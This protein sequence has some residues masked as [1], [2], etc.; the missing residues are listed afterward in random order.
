MRSTSVPGTPGVPGAETFH[1][2][3]IDDLPVYLCGVLGAVSFWSTA[4]AEITAVL[5]LAAAAAR[6]LIS[7]RAGVPPEFCR[8]RPSRIA[9]LLLAVYAPAT[10]VS[11]LL[12]QSPFLRNPSILWH[13]LLLPA[14][15]C[16]AV[17]PSTLR[18]AGVIFIA[19]GAASSVV[20]LAVNFGWS[21]AAGPF[22]FTGL[23]T[24]ADLLV[25]AGTAGLSLPGALP[26]VPFR[27]WPL[28][29]SALVL[30]AIAWTGERAPVVAL[31]GVG[32]VR[33]AGGGRRLFVAW[34]CIVAACVAIIP[35]VFTEK[36]DWLMSGRQIDRYVV[37]EEG[38]RLAPAAP[39]FG[40]GPGSFARV[41][42]LDAWGKFMQRPP[43]SWHNDLLETWL[44]SG[45]LAAVALGGLLVAGAVQALRG[46]SA[47]A[48]GRRR[49]AAG[50]AGLLFMILA[51]FGAVGSVVTTSVLGMAFWVLLGLTLAPPA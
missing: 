19:G 41:L 13:P 7:L 10:V 44:D 28:A 43:A 48:R 4:L 45:P 5:I 17:R 37:W 33:A 34:L 2:V 21:S 38:L 27:S 50:E 16:A 30:P 49:S 31:A 18:R 1:A 20:T 3:W 25:L 24:Y 6:A 26:P 39:L 8:T 9:F 23:T 36:M 29:A 35:R 11:V 47:S 46:L 42:P 14:L 12:A 22:T 51:L 40:Y 15:M 32:T